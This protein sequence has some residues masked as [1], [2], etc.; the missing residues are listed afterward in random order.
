MRPGTRTARSRSVQTI[1]RACCEITTDSVG[2]WLKLTHFRH[3]YAMYVLDASKLLRPA[4]GHLSGH[5]CLWWHRKSLTLPRLFLQARPL[6]GRRCVCAVAAVQPHSFVEIWLAARMYHAKS[7]ESLAARTSSPAKA[8]Q[9]ACAELQNWLP[10]N[11]LDAAP[12]NTCMRS[13]LEDGRWD[14]AL[15]IFRLMQEKGVHLESATLNFAL[16]ACARGAHWQNALELRGLSRSRVSATT[17]TFNILINAC[18][19]AHAWAM[20]LCVLEPAAQNDLEGPLKLC[21]V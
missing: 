15:N 13:C 16:H 14:I 8:W 4:C 21:P 17:T 2:A 20:A 5:L 9:T 7:N 3:S 19:R 6:P 12:Y 18:S 10:E 11:M 1:T